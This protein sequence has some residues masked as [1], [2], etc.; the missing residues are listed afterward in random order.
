M[1]QNNRHR[2][3]PASGTGEEIRQFLRQRKR[4]PVNTGLIILNLLVFLGVE[5]TG[6]ALDTNHMLRW[7]AM[8]APDIFQQ[9]EYYRLIT[10]MFLHFG[11]Q[12]LG[13]NMLVLLFLGDC[14]ERNV[15]KVRYFLVY[16]LGGFG[17]NCL[18]LWLELQNGEYFVSA[19]ASGAVFAVIGALIYVVLI[20]KGKIENFTTRQLLLMAA[21][22]RCYQ[23]RSRQR[24]SFWRIFLWIFPGAAALSETT[25]TSLLRGVRQPEE[26][27]QTRF[28]C[29]A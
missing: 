15:G 23:Y 11:I 29:E 17:A 5:G 12:H 9:G 27:F 21:L 14:L 2:Q 20:N 7:G 4:V 28:P 1:E 16:L 24:C 25:K 6:S 19:G 3:P 18:S 26:E 22:L 13:N 8:Y 10:S